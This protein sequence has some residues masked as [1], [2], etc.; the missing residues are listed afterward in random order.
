MSVLTRVSSWTASAL[1]AGGP[2]IEVLFKGKTK[3]VLAK[4]SAPVDVN[5]SLAFQEKG[6]YR[7]A[8]MVA[9]LEKYLEPWTPER[10]QKGDWKILMLDSYRAHWSEDI[11]RC[12]WE[13]GYLALY[14]Y[15]NTTGVMQVNDTHL[16]GPF[17]RIYL[18]YEEDAFAK[19]LMHDPGDI[20]R[21][22][23]QVGGCS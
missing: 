11:E 15:G 23:E 19:Q 17:K 10:A 22:R 20:S 18:N 5:V 8:D 1:R 12:C 6:S 7:S 14:H 2:P 13:R 21:S 16:H 9:Y 3:R 4:V